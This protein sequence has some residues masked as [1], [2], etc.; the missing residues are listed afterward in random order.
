MTLGIFV[1]NKYWVLVIYVY[2][3]CGDRIYSIYLDKFGLFN[4]IS[5]RQYS[6]TNLIIISNAVEIVLLEAILFAL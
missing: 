3:F 6:S 5:P 2:K 4:L 1:F